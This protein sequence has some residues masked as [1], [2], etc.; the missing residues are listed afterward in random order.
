MSATI[1]TEFDNTNNSGEQSLNYF[2][3]SL[4]QMLDEIQTTEGFILWIFVAVCIIL[5][6]TLNALVL[7]SIFRI[8]RTG[9]LKNR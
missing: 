1:D 6:F 9:K 7:R 3:S 8:K 2:E 4:Q 5:G